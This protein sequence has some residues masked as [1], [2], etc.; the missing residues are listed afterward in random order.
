MKHKPTKRIL[1]AKPVQKVLR[2]IS[3]IIEHSRASIYKSVNQLMVQSYWEIGRII[4][5]EEQLGKQ[6]ANYGSFLI[7]ELS[8]RLTRQYGKGYNSSNLW[9][10]RQFYNKFRKLHALRGELSWTHYRFLLKVENQPARNFYMREAIDCNWSTRTMERQINSL[11]YERMIL[12][13]YKKG[14]RLVRGE[15]ERLKINLNAS[16][17]IKDPYVLEFLELKPNTTFYEKDLEQALIDKLQEF[18]LELGK[19]FSFVGRQYKIGEEDEYYYVDL[20]FYNYILKCF[21]LIDLKTGKLT[22]QDIGQMDMYVRYFEDR[23]RQK[24][25]NPTLG[26]ILCTEKTKTIVKYSLLNE[27]KQLFASKYKLILP[28]EKELRKEVE[29]ERKLLETETKLKDPQTGK[30]RKSISK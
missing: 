29:R 3:A 26:I 12:T 30:S 14:K 13:P 6:R 5:E 21:V 1:T 28:S 18:L 10:M 17:V 16:D 20:V 15:S 8:L 11:Y 24:N 22:H 2:N 25:D 27:S 4:F 19:G 7:R 23:L 9:Y